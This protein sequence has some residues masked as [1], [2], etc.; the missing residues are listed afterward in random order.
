MSLATNPWLPVVTRGGRE[1]IRPAE[2][3]R[4]D[5]LRL[6]FPRADFNA[7]VTEFLIGLLAALRPPESEADWLRLYR[8]RPD[9]DALHGAFLAH[10]VAFDIERFMQTPGARIVKPVE[11]LIPETEG[12]STAAR[13]EDM[14]GRIGQIAA[15]S[16]SMA[17]AALITLQASA[18]EGGSGNRTSIRG[19]GPLS[20]LIALGDDLWGTVWPNVPCGEPLTEFPWQ[21]DRE[22]VTPDDAPPATVLW[23]MPRRIA[24]TFDGPGTCDLTGEACERIVREYR[25]TGG[26]VRFPG[27]S[28]PLT[29]YRQDKK[30]GAAPI[31][32]RAERIGMRHWLGYVQSTGDVL[33]ARCISTY[34]AHR[35]Q[36]GSARLVAHGYVTNQ[37]S[38]VGWQSGE[39]PVIIADPE[40]TEELERTASQMVGATREA[41]NRLTGAILSCGY[42]GHRARER[43]WLEA[44][45]EFWTALRAVPA[46][47]ASDADD[48]THDLRERFGRHLMRLSLRLF[49]ETCPLGRDPGR[50]TQTRHRL[51]SL[52]QRL[53]RLL[54]VGTA[55]DKEKRTVISDG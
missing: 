17:A 19:G 52:R 55:S 33:P 51:G 35:W 28:H 38:V 40:T 24:L 29:P 53:G 3:V 41:A 30:I 46:A 2:M 8:D 23:T 50:V 12:T 36:A 44:E 18:P 1:T 6:D 10:A 54:E 31:R 13:G 39:M 26:P 22:P 32:G 45:A 43:L 14:M 7:Y 42:S 9:V 11:G 34:R 47:M 37:A 16:P 25:E 15:L 5:V 27:W 48:P 21:H 49:D 4:P 20:T